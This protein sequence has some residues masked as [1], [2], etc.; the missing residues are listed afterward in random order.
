MAYKMNGGKEPGSSY[1]NNQVGSA[2][3]QKGLA[4]GEKKWTKEVRQFKPTGP[5]SSDS[6]AIWMRDKYKATHPSWKAI[7]DSA[8]TKWN[9][10]PKKVD[11]PDR[12]MKG[13]WQGHLMNI[14]EDRTK[15][16]QKYGLKDSDFDE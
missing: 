9:M 3:Q 12:V 5:E 15:G 8:Q 13:N 11:L 10:D 16:M 14:S 4:G 1:K 6:T 2:F 7:A